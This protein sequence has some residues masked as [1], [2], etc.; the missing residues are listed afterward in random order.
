MPIRGLAPTVPLDLSLGCH[1]RWRATHNCLKNSKKSLRR[2]GIARASSNPI[3]RDRSVLRRGVAAEIYRDVINIAPSPALR[4]IVAL[5]DRMSGGVK[6][7]SRVLSGRLVATANVAEM[8]TDPQMHPWTSAFKALLAASCAGLDLHDARDVGALGAHGLTLSGDAAK[9]MHGS[10]VS[11]TPE[12]LAQESARPRSW[13]AQSR[14]KFG[15]IARRYRHMI[16]CASCDVAGKARQVCR[17]PE[18]HSN[19]GG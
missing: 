5:D 9:L 8:P 14:N 12:A 15:A 2:S 19:L 3:L 4:R 17:L 16:S 6:M 13:E 11:V 18:I 7:L 1:R 10:Y